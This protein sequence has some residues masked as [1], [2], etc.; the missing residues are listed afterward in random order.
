MC[1]QL[2]NPT[3]SSCQ[4][5]QYLLLSKYELCFLLISPLSSMCLVI[6][7]FGDLIVVVIIKKLGYCFKRGLGLYLICSLLL[8]ICSFKEIFVLF[9]PQFSDWSL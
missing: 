6:C 1:R 5:P 8:K 3:L 9:C 2:M 7:D 4:I